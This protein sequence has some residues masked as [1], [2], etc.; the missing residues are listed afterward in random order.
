M[1]NFKSAGIIAKQGDARLT[2][3]LASLM[4]FLRSRGLQPLLDESADGL[5]PGEALHTRE[6]LVQRCDLAI[7]VGGDGTL[8]NAARSLACH[9]VPLIGINL[10][11]LGFLADI[12]PEE[13]T[14]RLDEILGGNY[15]EEPR[16]LLETEILRAGETIARHDALNDV[17]LHICGDVRMI[18]FDI[19]IDG[20]FVSSQRADGLVIATPTGSTAYALSGGGPILSPSLPAIGLVPI[21]PHTLTSRP[22]VVGSSA[23]I[24]ISLSPHN[25]T[26]AQVAFDGQSCSPI[27]ADDV[28]RIRQKDK[29]LR[30]LHPST[31]DHFHILRAKLH[32]GEQP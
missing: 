6:E 3:T 24:E 8:L 19:R 15:I 22:L 25:T 9:E 31:Y 30:L 5:A 11:R 17:V 1:R 7:V 21:C 18:E 26:P 16:A 10:G 28:I 29:P 20:H 13:M 4:A 32:W 27:T 12:S 2:P 23:C 14:L